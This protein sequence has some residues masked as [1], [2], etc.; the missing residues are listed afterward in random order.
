[1]NVIDS[2]LQEVIYAT[3]RIHNAEIYT[4]D[5]HFEGLVNVRYFAPFVVKS[6]CSVYGF[7]K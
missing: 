5:K 7:A 4:K 3:A 2:S 1:M 6:Y